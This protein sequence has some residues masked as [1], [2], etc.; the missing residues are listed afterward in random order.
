[1]GEGLGVGAGSAAPGYRLLE[2]SPSEQV[3]EA[4]AWLGGKWKSKSSLFINARIHS[5]TCMQRTLRSV[6]GPWVKLWAC[7]PLNSFLFW[8][9]PFALFHLLLGWE[10]G[11]CR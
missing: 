3:K 10:V 8:K 4:A 1:M 7:P 2:S 9:L 5:G 6:H 11:R